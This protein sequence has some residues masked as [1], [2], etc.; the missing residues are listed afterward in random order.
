MLCHALAEVH[1]SAHQP[2]WFIV[3]FIYSDRPGSC[4]LSLI[5][6]F[7]V[8][9]VS[10]GL[11]SEAGEREPQRQ[12]AR[13]RLHEELCAVL[14]RLAVRLDGRHH[15]PEVVLVVPHV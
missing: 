13:Q 1:E 2:S 11:A 9:L 4:V 10:T 12:Q 7:T 14:E 5:G 6:E 15:V 3:V 8:F